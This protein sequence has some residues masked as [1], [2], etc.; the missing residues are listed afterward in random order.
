MVMV[1]GNRTQEACRKQ[2]SERVWRLPKSFLRTVYFVLFGL[3]KSVGYLR[4]QDM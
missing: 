2:Q 1:R 3:A 4:I